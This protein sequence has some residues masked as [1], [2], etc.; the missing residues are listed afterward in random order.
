MQI[1]IKEQEIVHVQIS[2]KYRRW[3]NTHNQR[4]FLDKLAKKL[5]ITSYE[6]WYQV[7]VKTLQQHG[8][9]GILSKYNSSPKKLFPAIYPEYLL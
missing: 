2:P 1:L 5:N 7:S 3:N 6:G 9:S 8:V 4:T